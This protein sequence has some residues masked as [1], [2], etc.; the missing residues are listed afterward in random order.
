MA[1][2]LKSSEHA[3]TIALTNAVKGV[4]MLSCKDSASKLYEK[5]IMR[6]LHTPHEGY[7]IMPN[8]QLL[9]LYV[10]I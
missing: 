5:T 10:C 1:N 2:L 7:A 3:S 6:D 8:Q 4:L 9:Y